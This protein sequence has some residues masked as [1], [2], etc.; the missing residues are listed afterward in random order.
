MAKHKSVTHLPAPSSPRLAGQLVTAFGELLVVALCVVGVVTVAAWVATGAGLHIGRERPR[1]P[2]PELICFR[3]HRTGEWCQ[4]VDRP[5]VR[6]H[7]VAA[8]D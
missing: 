4:P 8:R 3:D 2:H 6:R 1:S 7:Y 5:P